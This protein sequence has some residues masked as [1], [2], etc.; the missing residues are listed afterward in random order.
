MG[1]EIL[2]VALIGGWMWGWPGFF[3][4]GAAMFVVEIIGTIIMD[5]RGRA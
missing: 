3:A 2:I 4:A 5:G 1:S